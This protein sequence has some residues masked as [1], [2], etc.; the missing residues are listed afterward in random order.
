M[1]RHIFAHAPNRALLLGEI[2]SRRWSSSFVVPFSSQPWALTQKPRSKA[3]FPKGAQ[4]FRDRHPRSEKYAH[5][6][7]FSGHW[8]FRENR[9]V[10]TALFL[11][12]RYSVASAKRS[13]DAVQ[14]SLIK[15]LNRFPWPPE[16]WF[17][18]NFPWHPQGS[19]VEIELH[20]TLVGQPHQ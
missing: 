13:S 19:K 8:S 3:T 10:L 7:T 18:T 6:S 17:G 12:R 20:L 14:P 1:F 2:G 11:E 16:L 9:A 4:W 5:L 15:G